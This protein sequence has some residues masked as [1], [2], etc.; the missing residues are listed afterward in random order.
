MSS[1][2]RFLKISRS[3]HLYL[4]VFTAPMLLFFAITGGLQT[5][6]LHETTRGSSY[7]PPAW[8]ASMGQLHKKQT[9]VMPVRRARPAETSMPA[10]NAD[11]AGAMPLPPANTPADARAAPSP[12]QGIAGVDARPKKNLLP[13]KIF[14]VVVSLGLLLSTLTGIYMAYRYSRKPRLISSVL[15]AGIVVPLLL[16]LF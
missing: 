1:A 14:F 15:V 11:P 7:T 16:L 4:G 3:V 10:T 5:F 12:G 13:M 9:T 8:L 6:S 2:H